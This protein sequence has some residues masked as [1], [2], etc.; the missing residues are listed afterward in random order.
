MLDVG[1]INYV[2]KGTTQHAVGCLVF[3]IFSF[4]L[5]AVS[6]AGSKIGAPSKHKSRSVT[7]F[8]PGVIESSFIIISSF[9]LHILLYLIRDQLLGIVLST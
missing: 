3:M 8:I 5:N 4:F 1:S 6:I 7:Y 9:L 2:V